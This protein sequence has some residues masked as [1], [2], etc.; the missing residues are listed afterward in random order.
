MLRPYRILD[1]L[2]RY[3]GVGVKHLRPDL[4]EKSMVLSA[5]A[6]PFPDLCKKS[7]DVS[8]IISYPLVW[9]PG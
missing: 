5:N 4:W 9:E 2:H 1:F 7:I 8:F 6:S 3:L